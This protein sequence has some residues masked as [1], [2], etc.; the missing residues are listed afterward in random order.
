MNITYRLNRIITILAILSTVSVFAFRAI[1]SPL[2]GAFLGSKV[3]V[4]D[5]NNTYAIAD[6]NYLEGGHMEVATHAALLAITRERRSIGMLVTVVDD[7]TGTVGNQTVTYQLISNPTADGSGG[8]QTPT[9]DANWIVIIP[10]LGGNAGKFLTT[11]GTKISWAASAGGVTSYNGRTGA[12]MPQAGDIVGA[13]GY[14]P[15]N[16]ANKGASNGY[17]SLDVSGKVPTS[18]LPASITGAVVYQGSWDA[19]TNTPTLTSGVGTQGQYYVVSNAGTTTLDGISSWAVGDWAVFSGSVWQKIS[20]Q[21]NVASVNSATGAIVLTVANTGSALQ[22]SGVQLQI[23]TATSSVA[24]LLSATDWT[25]FNNKQNALT[26]GDL[27]VGTGLSVT[28][29][30]G[31]VIG[32]GAS[33]SLGT[34]V[35]TSVTNDTNITGAISNNVLTL[36]FA[37]QLPISR[38]GT[39][40][41]SL[42]TSGQ[43][44]RSN[45]TS[46]EYF[47]PNYISLSALS[48]GTGIS[49]DNTT[50]VISV[51]NIPNS[52]LTNSGITINGTPVA[53]GGSITGLLTTN[54]DGSSLTNIV[55]SFNGRTGAV[56]PQASDYATNYIQNTTTQQASSNFNISGAGT[57]GGLLTAGTFK[58]VAT[59]G[60]QGAFRAQGTYSSTGSSIEDFYS[61][62]SVARSV[63]GNLN[64]YSFVAQ[65]TIGATNTGNITGVYGL[66]G[67][68]SSPLLAAG[69]TGTLSNREGVVI[70]ISNFSA[71]NITNSYGVRLAS[72]GNSGGGTLTNFAGI[73]VNNV[74]VATNNTEVLTGTDSIPAGNWNIYSSTAYNNYLGTGSTLIG[75]QTL[76]PGNEQLQV[77]GASKFQGSLT[78][79]GNGSNV[80]VT[81]GI[82]STVADNSIGFNFPAASFVNN[83][84]AGNGLYVQGGNSTKYAFEAANYLGTPALTVL[85]DGTT[86]IAGKLGVGT[87]PSYALQVNGTAGSSIAF[88]MSNSANPTLRLQ[89]SSAGVD[90]TIGFYDSNGVLQDSIDGNLSQGMFFDSVP[91]SYHFR[92][93]SGTDRLTILGNGNVGIGV[94]SPQNFLAVSPVQYNTGTA[95]QSGTTVTGV[96][97]TFTPA[98]IGSQFIFSD[99]H[100]EGV[101]TAVAD[102][103]HLTV[104]NSDTES[105]SAY[106]IYYV[107]LQVDTKGRVAIGA[108]T[109]TSVLTVA[110]NQSVPAWGVNGIGL[111]VA[112]AAYTDSSTAANGTVAN[113]AVNSLGI[114]ALNASNTN[115]VD[116]TASTLYIAGAP[117]GGANLVINSPLALNVASGNTYFGGNVGFGTKNPAVAADIVGTSTA[118]TISTAPG[119]LRIENAG[120]TGSIGS[121]DFYGSNTNGNRYPTARIGSNSYGYGPS[122]T[123]AGDLIFATANDFNTLNEV[124]RLTSAG[125]V[126]IGTTTPSGALTIAGNRSAAAW[127]LN[128]INFQAA[129]ATYTDTS[130]PSSTFASV[131]AINS[132]GIP[133]VAA[134]NSSIGYTDLSTVYIAGA[135]VAGTNVN[136]TNPFALNVAGGTSYFG[137]AVQIAGPVQMGNNEYLYLKDNT[138]QSFRAFGID[139][140]NQEIIGGAGSLTFTGGITKINFASSWSQDTYTQKYQFDGD[141]I[142]KGIPSGTASGLL[143][144]DS[145]SGFITYGNKV[146]TNA[147]TY[148]DAV[149]NGTVTNTSVNSFGIPTLASTNAVTYTNASTLY[150]AGAPLAGTNT[151]I[152]NPWALNVASGNAYF[153]GRV[154]IGTTAPTV[155]LSVGGSS[156]LT[157]TIVAHFENAGGT[158]DITPSTTGGITCSSDMNL[159]K[160]ITLLADSSPWSFNNNIAVAN[161]SDLDKILALTPV[162]YNWNVEQDTDAKHAGFIAQEVQQ[163]FPDLV[164]TNPATHLLSLNYTGLIP[165]TI[166]AIQEMNVK[167]TAIDDLTKSNS[168]RDALINWFAD[169]ANG[170]T[171]IFA[172]KVTT[173][174]LCVGTT[175]VTQQQFLQLIQN[176]N[177]SGSSSSSSSTTT[178][179]SAP[180]T[181]SGSSDSTQTPSTDSATVTPPA[182]DTT[183]PSPDSGS[184][185]PATAPT[186]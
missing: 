46:L 60:T 152:T 87:T 160:N 158:C 145:S 167:I 39:G 38:G 70:D 143:Y 31:A 115:V 25:T 125:N 56:V 94:F 136:I 18:Q 33:I 140:S 85:G 32:S 12:V 177:N 29:G 71:M 122:N 34:A 181:D 103:T 130:T 110:G 58:S 116:T 27:T 113:V 148:T 129:P 102:A 62:S 119:F 79:T 162:N 45:G 8:T 179:S 48:G 40:L 23:P 174:E 3:T 105:S 155:L 134:T 171:N 184:S 93:S 104:S 67:L 78:V 96:G 36:S 128:G 166:A 175:C 21:G 5:T 142:W 17:A 81:D 47:T 80:G 180:V 69:A 95:S 99:S 44:V 132:F 123:S 76:S 138:G 185:D 100:N 90:P 55:T 154:G 147:F 72:I 114:A 63:S 59:V 133:T 26:F 73:A 169:S 9:T 176:S 84:T 97:T 117:T 127:G 146:Q 77:T 159:K 150:I 19:S 101:I 164:S 106:T 83:S 53:L 165:Y 10:S 14:V 15:E 157:G 91:G 1:A 107:G 74:V 172:K 126:G 64:F 65:N 41:S 124:M 149:S 42:G 89:S 151:T 43:L 7:D 61:S 109:P 111:Q 11:D 28:G 131:T 121:L 75:S 35:P 54:G 118:T 153:G 13:L 37:G 108:T 2:P 88:D 24:G 137:G 168:W 112:G 20:S 182:S 186:Q 92:N 51:A 22:W 30:T 16:A 156:V 170:I 163:I 66:A 98:L 173:D 120:N 82:I 135:P 4:G 141:V 52:A 49:Y 144:Y 50:G 161:D 183:A 57:L 178:S 86:T 68:Y 139:N 6:A